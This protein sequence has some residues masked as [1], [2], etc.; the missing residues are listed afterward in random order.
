MTCYFRI[1]LLL[2]VF[3]DFHAIQHSFC[4]LNTSPSGRSSTIGQ[5]IGEAMREITEAQQPV[6]S[7]LCNFGIK[8]QV[9]FSKLPNLEMSWPFQNRE[10]VKRELEKNMKFHLGLTR[11][12]R[13]KTKFFISCSDTNIHIFAKHQSAWIA[14]C[15][16]YLCIEQIATTYSCFQWKLKYGGDQGICGDHLRNFFICQIFQNQC[17]MQAFID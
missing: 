9:I 15:I 17:I 5:K 16:F 11:G 7:T 6:P 12:Q 1:F 4:M 13:N 3:P 8:I 10:R 2:H 14:C